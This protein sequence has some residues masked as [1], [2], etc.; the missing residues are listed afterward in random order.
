[1]G[2]N[3][4]LIGVLTIVP[5][6]ELLYNW[7]L[8]LFFIVSLASSFRIES[9]GSAIESVLFYHSSKLASIMRTKTLGSLRAA[10]GFQ[11]LLSVIVERF[12]SLSHDDLAGEVSV[13]SY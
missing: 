2:R 6:K 1:M 5:D 11:H 4:C 8:V 12:L 7:P 9:T 13:L 10:C 3:I